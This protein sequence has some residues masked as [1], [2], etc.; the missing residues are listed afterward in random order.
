[1]GDINLRNRHRVNHIGN[2]RRP[3]FGITG[4]SGILL[5]FSGLVLSMVK[6][7][8]FDFEMSGHDAVI[9]SVTIVISAFLISLGVMIAFFGRFTRSELFKK[10]ALETTEDHKKGYSVAQFRHPDKMIG[11]VGTAASDLRPA[12][13]VEVAKRPPHMCSLMRSS[14]YNFYIIKYF[15]FLAYNM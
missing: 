12:G 5:T 8:G 1:M 6:N 2:I 4:I 14:C 7:V 3:G 11:K 15:L 13:K 9:Q 10:L